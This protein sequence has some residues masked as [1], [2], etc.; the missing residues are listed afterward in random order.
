MSQAGDCSSPGMTGVGAAFGLGG[1]HYR[2]WEEPPIA[3]DD[4][5]GG[6]AGGV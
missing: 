3:W 5:G 2:R 1:K 6:M 4:G